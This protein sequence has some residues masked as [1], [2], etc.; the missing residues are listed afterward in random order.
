MKRLG[1]TV[2]ILA[3]V[4]VMARGP[5][6]EPAEDIRTV[7]TKKGHLRAEAKTTLPAVTQLTQGV[8]VR[9]LEQQGDF[10][11]VKEVDGPAQGWIDPGQLTPFDLFIERSD[12]QVQK[13]LREGDVTVAAR[14]FSLEVE[15]ALRE[16]PEI[17]EGYARLDAL[18]DDPRFEPDIEALERF[19]REG[20]L[21]T[22]E[23]G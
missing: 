5:E 15:K 10:V 7:R 16:P 19:R 3:A 9:V 21:A 11:F 1:V 18:A 13:R 23:E 8:R 4:S 20:Q 14:S 22:L 2:L 12:P 17:Q 6:D